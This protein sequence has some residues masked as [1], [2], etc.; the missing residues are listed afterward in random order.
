VPR[1]VFEATE[2]ATMLPPPTEGFDVPLWLEK[3]TV[4]PDHHVQVARALYSV[5]TIYLYKTVRARADRSIVKIYLGT[6]LIKVHPRKPAGGRSTDPNDYPIGKAPYALRSVEA[7]LGKARGMGPHIGIYAERLLAG[8]LPWTRMRQVYALLR[9]CDK[10]TAGRVEAICQSAL[11]FDVVDVT[12][13]TRMLKTASKAAAQSTD[14]KVVQLALP[15]FA[16]PGEHFQTRA[17]STKK[18]GQ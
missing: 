10:F 15:R 9:L 12:R 6:E 14:R 4:H 18:E 8:P 16:R 7:L 5:P 11:S 17:G 2:K 1:E 13:I 3:L